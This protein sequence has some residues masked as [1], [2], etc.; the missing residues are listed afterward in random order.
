VVIGYQENP[1]EEAL[2]IQFFNRIQEVGVTNC[3]NR[4]EGGAVTVSF[5]GVQM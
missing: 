3:F 1:V 2:P 5:A 4:L